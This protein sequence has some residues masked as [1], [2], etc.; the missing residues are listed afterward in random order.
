MIAQ[1]LNIASPIRGIP[2]HSV[3]SVDDA[4]VGGNIERM[5][6]TFMNDCKTEKKP[7]RFLPYLRNLS[8]EK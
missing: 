2:G 3:F 4:G 5:T 8:Y 7:C 1:R 6:Q